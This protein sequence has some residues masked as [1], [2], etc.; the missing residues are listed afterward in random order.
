MGTNTVTGGTITK[1]WIGVI[2]PY[3]TTIAD[4]VKKNV[5]MIQIV[6]PL[7]VEAPLIIAVGGKGGNVLQIQRKLRQQMNM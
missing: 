6:G 7:N 3:T 2:I 5:S 4:S 1:A